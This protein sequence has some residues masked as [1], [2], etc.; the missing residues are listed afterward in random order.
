M[1]KV[2]K[3]DEFI[4][5]SL[6]LEANIK[7]EKD[8]LNIIGNINSPIKDAILSLQDKDVDVNQNYLDIVVDKE[9]T[10]SFLQDDRVEKLRYTTSGLDYNRYNAINH[11]Y[12]L[13]TLDTSYDNLVKINNYR[14]DDKTVDLVRFLTLEDK[15]REYF[16]HY[17]HGGHNVAIVKIT[18]NGVDQ[19][20]LGYSLSKDRSL[21]KR[22]EIKVGRFIRTLLKKAEVEFKDKEIEDFVTKYKSAMKIKMESF[23]RFSLVDKE[24]IRKW[25]LETN[26]EKT[27]GTLGGSCMRYSKCQNYLD[28]YV[29]NPDKVSM[30]IL[31]SDK[32]DDKISGRAI[33]W[34]VD[35]GR[36]VMDRIYTNNHADIEFFIQYA[37]LN[38]YLY[39]Y[40]QSYEPMPFVLNGVKLSS[41]ESSCVITLDL[42]H[43]TFPYMDTFKYKNDSDGSL[44]N[45]YSK[46]YDGEL[47]DTEGGDGSCDSCGGRGTFECEECDDGCQDCYECDGRGDFM[48][49][50]CDGDG[51]NECSDCDGNGEIE[52][53]SCDGNGCESCD[54]TGNVK[55]ENCSGRGNF[56]CST[57]DGDG[58]TE[59]GECEGSGNQ[60]CGCCDGSTRVDCYNCS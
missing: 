34:T 4:N 29:K 23:S 2:S 25:Y 59:C 11:H 44:T 58:R 15:G 16:E 14:N 12:D 33:L 47:T 49:D 1:R 51:E 24:D 37:N 5:E 52:C 10:V 53:S 13:P 50:D 36:K 7:Y 32:D 21:V 38:N 30:V 8:F 54:D 57:C 28:I 56:S 3:Y 46:H 42:D 19:Y 60:N 40:T 6:I 55:C 18:M 48:C 41:A 39:K 31:K 9:D 17:I 43:D 27:D 20:M 22:G 45:D 26:Y 35:D